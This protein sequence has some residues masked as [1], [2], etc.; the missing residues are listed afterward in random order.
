[1]TKL[2]LLLTLVAP[3]SPEQDRPPSL[4]EEVL[5]VRKDLRL[6]NP[7]ADL[8]GEYTI[9]EI[10]DFGYW[11]PWVVVDLDH[12]QRPDVVAVVVTRAARQK[13]FGVIAVHAGRPSP[14]RWVVPL[15]PRLLNG[16]AINHPAPDTVMPL[17]CIECDS[18]PWYRWNGHAYEPELYAVGEAVSVATYLKRATLGMFSR[19]SRT[20]T[21]TGAVESCTE[22]RVLRRRGTSYKTR[23]YFIEVEASGRRGWVP[24]SFLAESECIG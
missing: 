3:T 17:Y 14:L 11:P 1:M 23:W 15:G 4:L 13:R 10:K 12:D 19:P 20:S 22:A 7:A 5:R 24:A 6:L 16:V 8:Q 18:N 9:E 21:F 2:L